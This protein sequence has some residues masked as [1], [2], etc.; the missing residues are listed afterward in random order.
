M[1]MP[2]SQWNKYT[3]WCGDHNVILATPAMNGDMIFLCLDGQVMAR[4]VEPVA[5]YLRDM[6]RYR[7]F[8]SGSK[9]EIDQ[10]LREQKEREPVESLTSSPPRM[11]IAEP[12]C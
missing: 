4:Y 5:G 12:S 10:Q 9:D 8:R 11:S 7:K 1:V 6:A 2:L 3:C